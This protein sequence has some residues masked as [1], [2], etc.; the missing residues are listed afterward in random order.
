MWEKIKKMRDCG[1]KEYARKLDD[2]FAN[3][4]RISAYTN[5]PP[6]KVIM[7]Y[8]MKHIDGINAYIDGH[9]S[10]REDVEGRIIDAQV[11]LFLLSG[12]I[13][14]EKDDKV[15]GYP[16]FTKWVASNTP[17]TDFEDE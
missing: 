13:T 4:K 16:A 3:F 10:Q 2:V 17:G 9:T 7:V 15:V 8:L 5:I 6:S 12:Y 14:A 1:Q 11:Y